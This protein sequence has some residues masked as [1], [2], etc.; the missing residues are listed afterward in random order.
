MMSITFLIPPHTK[1]K[2][3]VAHYIELNTNW[4]VIHKSNILKTKFMSKGIWHLVLLHVSQQPARATCT[5][6]T[7]TRATCTRATCTRATCTRATCTCA[8]CTRATCTRATCTC[9]TC[10]RATCEPA[11]SCADCWLTQTGQNWTSALPSL[12]SPSLSATSSSKLNLAS[13][14]LSLPQDPCL[15]RQQYRRLFLN[16]LAVLA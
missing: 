8:T 4:P 10:T 1:L 5:R 16:G 3:F 9:A 11:R 15:H 2:T 12:A 14:K 6:A 13:S 7:C